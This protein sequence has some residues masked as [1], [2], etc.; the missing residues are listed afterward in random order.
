MSPHH[1]ANRQS[2]PA[3]TGGESR[4]SPPRQ[5]PLPGCDALRILIVD[6]HAIVRDGLKRVLAEHFPKA[7]LSAARNAQEALDR[8]T[9]ELW[10][11]ILL[12]ISM[13]GQSGLD[14]LKQIKSLRPETKVLVLTM[15]PEDQYALR[16]L[17]A[18]ASGYLTK[19]TASA[20]V[21][22]AIE[23]VLAGGKYLSAALAENLVGNLNAPEPTAPHET[24]SDREY[25][26]FRMIALGKSV[27]EIAFDLSLSIK[28]VST[29][30]TRV[31]TKFAFTSNAEVIRYALKEKLVE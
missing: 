1:Q 16:V 5:F 25:Q 2:S 12:D 27:K 20:V 3:P 21:T 19:E 4:P 6:D 8:V 14:V 13:P 29:Y 23:K 17:K 22:Q 28:T 15:Y 31:L 11:V 24:L 10:S 18:G 26:V 30:R 7:I 9:K